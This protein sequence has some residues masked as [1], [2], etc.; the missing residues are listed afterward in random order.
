MGFY[1]Y[2]SAFSYSLIALSYIMRDIFWLRVITLFACFMDIY[3]YFFIRPGQPMWIQIA[4]NLVFIAINAYQLA[5]LLK[6]KKASVLSGEA[7]IIHQQV[8][9]AFSPVE[10]KKLLD[11]ARFEDHPKDH[12]LVRTNEKPCDLMLILQGEAAILANGNKVSAVGNKQF[13]G[14]MSFLTEQPASAT[15]V[16]SQPTRILRL[17]HAQLDALLKKTPELKA[18]LHSVLG[19]DV[20]LKLKKMNHDKHATDA[21]VPVAA[22]TP[23]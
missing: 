11:V 1:D 3:I 21:V 16:T 20:A 9:Q 10:F 4:M 22:A 12:C 23:A 18:P 6:E 13:L 2:L 19:Q 15:A 5:I 17:P 14:E 8:F 7:K